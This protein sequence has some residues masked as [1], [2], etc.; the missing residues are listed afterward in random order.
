MLLIG[1]SN[2]KYLGVLI[3]SARHLVIDIDVTVR[4][5]YMESNAVFSNCKGIDELTKL[6]LQET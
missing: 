4:K 1:A 5:F 3:K 2:V 6:R